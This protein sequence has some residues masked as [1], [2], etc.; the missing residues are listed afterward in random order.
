MTDTR[1]APSGATLGGPQGARPKSRQ[2]ALA[3]ICVGTMMAFVN[4]SS[5]IGALA[6]IQA[7]LHSSPTA[8]V[9]ITSAYSLVVASLILAAGTLS[10]VVGRRLV[11]GLGVGFFIVG[12][13]AAAAAADST[14]L[15]IAAQAVIGVGGALL[16]PSGL[17]IV[18]NEFSDPR[19]RTEAVSV[20]AGSSGLGLAIGPV[21]SGAILSH[22]SWHAIFSINIVLGVLALAGTV[23][24]IPTAGTPGAAWTRS[25]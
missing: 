9:W 25:G 1:L 6:R 5:T 22:H 11:F 4:V 3:V 14:G 7:D 15:L 2:L 13:I 10:D 18:S 23:L 19:Q 8:I 20:W 21:G 24:F 12:S 16:L 17:S